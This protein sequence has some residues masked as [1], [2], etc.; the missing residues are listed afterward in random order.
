VAVFQL[1][2]KCF[3]KAPRREGRSAGIFVKQL[4]IRASGG[5]QPFDPK[6]RAGP[7]NVSQSMQ[8]AAGEGS[9]R[10]HGDS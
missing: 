9:W 10:L 7:S 4:K 6:N 8:A 3:L 5:E 1:V 2:E